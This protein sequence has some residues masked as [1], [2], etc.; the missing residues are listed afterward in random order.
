M[1]E[2]IHAVE[3]YIR[4]LYDSPANKKK[5]AQRRLRMPRTSDIK[6]AL[7]QNLVP[8]KSKNRRSKRKKRS[9]SGLRKNRENNRDQS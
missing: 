2:I 9:E 8:K 1:P 6:R 4:S 7:V 3:I 5:N